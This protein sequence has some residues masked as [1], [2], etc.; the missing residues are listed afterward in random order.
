MLTYTSHCARFMVAVLTFSLLLI[1]IAA[2]PA[3]ADAA[4]D[5]LVA[6]MTETGRPYAAVG[7]VT[8][9][10]AIDGKGDDEPWQKTM[11]LRPFYTGDAG[12]IAS[13]TTTAWLGW[14]DEH[15]YVRFHCEEPILEERRNRLEDFH[16]AITQDDTAVWDDQCVALLIARPEGEYVYDLFVNANAALADGRGE[17]PDPW[18]SRDASFDTGAQVEASVTEGAW[19]AELAVPWSALGGPPDE[20]PWRICLG[21]MR[22]AISETS[23]WRAPTDRGLHEFNSFGHALFVDEPVSLQVTPPEDLQPG[24]NMATFHADPAMLPLAISANLQAPDADD[25][26]RHV[27][28]WDVGRTR[29]MNFTSD[30][31]GAVDFT[32]NI[33][34]TASGLPFYLSPTMK[35]TIEKSRGTISIRTDGGWRVT[36]GDETIADGTGAADDVAIPFQEGINVLAITFEGGTGSF[37]GQFHGI[38][39]NSDDTWVMAGGDLP[40]KFHAQNFDTSSMKRASVVGDSELQGA[41]QVGADSGPVTVRKMVLW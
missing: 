16:R 31:R 34:D 6:L 8:S 26:T 36:L 37:A 5:D 4:A 39:L 11:I 3:P 41:S 28:L 29:D 21:R 30:L 32:L 35:R 18:S 10:P 15:L 27:E 20:T 13:A 7:R 17:L 33:W 22:K 38:S 1:S 24:T 2:L 9:P 12:E 40:E 19:E 23:A 25:V 14:D